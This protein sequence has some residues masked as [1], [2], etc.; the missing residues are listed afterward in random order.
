MSARIERAAR[1]WSESGGRTADPGDAAD[2]VGSANPVD[3]GSDVDEARWLD[4]ASATVEERLSRA[5][6]SYLVKLVGS[7]ERR[8]KEAAEAA[9]QNPPPVA[10]SP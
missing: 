8:L 3:S 4:R 6:Q 1:R 7:F 9:R 10:S 5:G 2:P